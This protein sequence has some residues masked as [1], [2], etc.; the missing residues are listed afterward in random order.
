MIYYIADILFSH[1][2]ILK[3]EHRPF[4]SLDEMNENIINNWNASVSEN[5]TVYVL[6]DAFWGKDSKLE[7]R[8]A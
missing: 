4:E 7:H 8:T 2:N 5:D 1:E 6:G 3:L